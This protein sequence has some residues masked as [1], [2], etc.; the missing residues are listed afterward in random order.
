MQKMRE[1]ENNKKM[2]ILKMELKSM[3]VHSREFPEIIAYI[4]QNVHKIVK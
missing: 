3:N 2:C 4:L 1:S